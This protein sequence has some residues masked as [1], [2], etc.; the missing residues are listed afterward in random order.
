MHI[1][2]P[3]RTKDTVNTLAR[4]WE[5]SVRRSHHFLTEADIRRI[6]PLVKSGLANIERL[7][8]AY[9]QNEPAGFIGLEKNKIEMLFVAPDFWGMGIGKELVLMAFRNFNIR[10]VD[11]NEQ[12][13]QAEGFYRHLGFR[14]FER[15]ETDGQGNPFPILKM[16]RE[17]FSLRHATPEDIPVLKTLFT[18]TV[19][20]TN[21]K[22]PRGSGRLGCVCRQTRPLERIDCHTPFYV[23]RRIPRTYRRLRSYPPGRLFE[24]HVR[25]PR[26]PTPRHRLPASGRHGKIRPVARR[27]V[28]HV[29]SQPD[30]PP[31]LRK[32]RLHHR[33][34][35]AEKSHATTSDKFQNEETNRLR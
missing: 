28:H 1:T 8:V 7:F 17:R 5:A 6:T 3:I 30:S 16:E 11:V 19:L 2:S 31:V 35:A 29:R 13:P 27:F 4:L 32:Q 22:D 24:L 21:R 14:T 20:R 10:Y 23:G 9:V 34:K 15:T 12:N 25:A 26:L 33:G 18:D